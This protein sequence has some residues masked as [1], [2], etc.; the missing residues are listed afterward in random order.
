[1][2]ANSKRLNSPGQH[3]QESPTAIETGDP[4]S[5]IATSGGQHPQESPTAI[6]TK[7]NDLNDLDDGGQ[8]PQESPTAI[9][10]VGKPANEEAAKV[11]TPKNRPP[12]LKQ[13]LPLATCRL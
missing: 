13:A 5:T 1:M 9:E 3:P 12:R 10:T 11:S 4:M 7:P 6:E 2:N 8:H